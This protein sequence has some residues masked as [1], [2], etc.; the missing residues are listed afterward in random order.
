MRPRDT[1]ERARHFFETRMWS[2]R[3]ENLGWGRR[4]LYRLGRA[5]YATTRGFF[6]KELTSRAASLTYYTMLSIVP[7]L[8]F[9]FS[10]LKG[11]GLYHRLMQESLRPYLHEAFK[12]DA[13]LLA[14]LD[15]MLTFVERTGVSGLSVVGILFLI[16][17]SL[18][19]LSTVESSLNGIWDVHTA[20]PLVRKF[21]DYTTILVIGPLLIL[22]AI[23]L[24][25]A[26]QSS[27]FVAFL[28]RSFVVGG[29]VDFCLHLATFILGCAGLV[30]LYVLMPNTRVRL[31]SA[32]FG[33]L[34]AGALWQGALFLHVKFQIGVAKYNALYSGFAAL[35]I[36]LVWLYLSWNIV[37]VGAGLAASHQHEQLMRQALRARHVDQELKE[38]LA[39]VVAAAVSRS[40][41]DG[42]PPPTAAAL[43]E[44]LEVP[45]PAVE[46]VLDALVSAGLLVRVAESGELRYDPARDV[47]AVRVVD[48]E[49]AVRHDPSPEADA[50]RSALERTAGPALS[51]LLRSRRHEAFTESG[52]L[53]LRELARQCPREIDGVTAASRPSKD[54]PADGKKPDA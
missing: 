38:H 49:E 24:G 14:A 13:S 37:L 41:I 39:V 11:F 26:A 52:R 47:D 15:Q 3:L 20:R 44:A 6:D 12:G 35:P 5:I 25:A 46:E 43:A 1:Y 45:P 42:H 40:F 17:T 22:A 16:Y 53:T 8:A 54:A 33:G 31:S 29:I 30:A 21:T 18:S 2:A 4:L 28:H 51:S 7:F 19:M 10:L 23:T 27:N 36:F 32:L 34:V 48:V 9:V 50:V